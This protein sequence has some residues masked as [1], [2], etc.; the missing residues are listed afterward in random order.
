MGSLDVDVES[1]Y[2]CLGVRLGS[3]AVGSA[4]V[5]DD[6]DWEDFTCVTPWEDFVRSLEDVLRSWNAC[7]TGGYRVYPTACL[8]G[9]FCG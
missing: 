9:F 5:E 4:A 1:S 3:T 8:Q 7:D 6:G 2:G